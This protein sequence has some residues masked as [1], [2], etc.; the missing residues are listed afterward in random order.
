[1]NFLMMPIFFLSGSL[2]PL[3]GLPDWM[4]VL[5]R[6]D[7]AT[8]GMDPLRRVMLEGAGLPA[9]ALDRLSLTIGD[10]I[11]PIWVEALILLAF[12]LVALG[13]AIAAFRVRD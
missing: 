10:W 8:Y 2:F 11:V 4:T 1:M 12:G 6:L 7:P 13:F 5:T 3:N 9:A